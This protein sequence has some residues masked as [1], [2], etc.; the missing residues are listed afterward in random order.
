M[1]TGTAAWFHAVAVT[2]EVLARDHVAVVSHRLEDQTV[3]QGERGRRIALLVREAEGQLRPGVGRQGPALDLRAQP[4]QRAYEG[5]E[6]RGAG[7]RSAG[8]E[9]GLQGPRAHLQRDQR[10]LQPGGLAR[11]EAQQ[12]GQRGVDLIEDVRLGAAPSRVGLD[13]DV[14]ELPGT[15]TGLELRRALGAM[16]GP[17]Q[18]AELLPRQPEERIV[19]PGLHHDGRRAGQRFGVAAHAALVQLARLP[20]PQPRRQMLWKAPGIRGRTEGLARQ[21]RRRLMV[22]PAAAGLEGQ[23]QDDVRAEGPDHLHH[24]PERLLVAPLREGLFDAEGIAGLPG[25]AEELVHAVVA[26]DG[27]E[28]L[29]AQHAEG[30]RQLG[31][32]SFWPPSPRVIVSRPVVQ[33]ASPR[34]GHQHA[35]VLVVGM[36]GHVEDAAGHAQTAQG[37]AQTGGALVQR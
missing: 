21:P 12:P 10:R 1:R 11:R 18:A 35:V 7:L 15:R 30:E 2:T 37:Q 16:R 24:V 27:G 25:A 3:R 5:G 34:E 23:G 32:I 6:R 26:V 31:P 22:L 19:C 20:G 33:P 4:A 29:G 14:W 17:G 13:K 8:I 9:V 28:L 36:R